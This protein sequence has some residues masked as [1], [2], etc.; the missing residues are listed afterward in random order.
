MTSPPA[1]EQPAK[2]P[3]GREARCPHVVVL[4]ERANG[5]DHHHQNQQAAEEQD[6]ATDEQPPQDKPEREDLEKY[7]GCIPVC[8]ATE[9]TAGPDGNDQG[10]SPART[11]LQV[12]GENVV[13][14]GSNPYLRSAGLVNQS[15]PTGGP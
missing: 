7:R 4:A 5:A 2:Q 13:P 6:E 10:A 3:S 8:H 11:T 14:D 12:R 1:K 9:S 15:S